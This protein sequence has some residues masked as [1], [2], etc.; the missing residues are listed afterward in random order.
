M[1][2]VRLPCSARGYNILNNCIRTAFVCYLSYMPI[3]ISRIQC[4]RVYVYNHTH[5]QIYLFRRVIMMAIA[6]MI[7]VYYRRVS[8]YYVYTRV[9]HV[10][11][12]LYSPV[13]ND[14]S[15]F[16]IIRVCLRG[17]TPYNH[18]YSGGDGAAATCS[19]LDFSRAH[20]LELIPA[21]TVRT[22]REIMKLHYAAVRGIKDARTKCIMIYAIP[23]P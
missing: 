12:L 22:E 10:V 17:T 19:G 20:L 8:L 1:D 5:T 7:Y 4:V 3:P 13:G 21:N 15:V 18:L 11:F 14:A 6:Y 2:V 16:N 9:T 23:T